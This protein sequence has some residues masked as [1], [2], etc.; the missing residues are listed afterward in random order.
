MKQ[1]HNNDS[2]EMHA[3]ILLYSQAKIDFRS[4]DFPLVHDRQAFVSP[5]PAR[6]AWL[7]LAGV[8]ST[9]QLQGRRIEQRRGEKTP[10]RGTKKGF[11]SWK[12]L[13]V[14]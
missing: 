1:D 8:L 2:G 3:V 10:R 4:L 5:Y 11:S 12:G 9:G 6:P 13:N 14:D 7:K